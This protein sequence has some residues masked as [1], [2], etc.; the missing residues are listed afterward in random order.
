MRRI[1][2]VLFVAAVSLAVSPGTLSAQVRTPHTSATAFPVSLVSP[3]SAAP[4]SLNPSALGSLDSWSLAYSHVDATPDTAYA[5]KFDALWLPF[6]VFDGM[7]LGF[8]PEF[9][10]ARM[11]GLV[12]TNGC[13]M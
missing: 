11:P 4:V 8:G 12:D 6:P 1:A 9:M 13:A 5:D 7:A 2:P 10:R 3:D